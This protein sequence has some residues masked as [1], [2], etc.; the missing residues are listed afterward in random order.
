MEKN[1]LKAQSFYI[2]CTVMTQIIAVVASSQYGGQSV[3]VKHLG[4]YLRKS[5]EKYTKL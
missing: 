2:A 1:L 4:K 3:D 5:A